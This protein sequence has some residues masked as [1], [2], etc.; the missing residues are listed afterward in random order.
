MN[1][2]TMTSLVAQNQFGTLIDASQRQPVT[3]TRRGRPVMVTMSYE[4]YVQ[5]TKTIPY[6]VFKLISANFPLR[7]KEAGDAMRSMLNSLPNTATEEGL[8]EE[9]VMRMLNEEE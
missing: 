6:E 4:D 5:R 1:M 2:L 8:T 7:G 3:V 9:D